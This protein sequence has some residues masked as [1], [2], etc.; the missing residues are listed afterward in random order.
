MSTSCISKRA[1]SRVACNSSTKDTHGAYAPRER[2][3]CEKKRA[4]YHSLWLTEEKISIEPKTLLWCSFGD[5]KDLKIETYVHCA[6][7][8]DYI[9]QIFDST[10]NI[11]YL[12]SVK[13]VYLSFLFIKDKIVEFLINIFIQYFWN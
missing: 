1:S 4:I 8:A 3:E 5:L 11:K 2:E 10:L 9:I 7:K 13:C 12:I 6:R